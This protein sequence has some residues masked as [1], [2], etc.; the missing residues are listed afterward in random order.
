MRT[1]SFRNEPAGLVEV[2]SF[3]ADAVSVNLD[4]ST[5]C[6]GPEFFYPR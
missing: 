2:K 1:P 4:L 3:P 5:P 6:T